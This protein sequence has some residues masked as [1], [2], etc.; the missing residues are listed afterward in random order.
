[1]VGTSLILFAV[2]TVFMRNQVKPIRRLAMAADNF[3]KGRDVW[4]FKPE[5][6]SE[7]RRAASAFLAMRDRIGRQD[8]SSIGNVER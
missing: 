2:A 5:G 8:A 7:V 6:A 1:M 3:G 4:N